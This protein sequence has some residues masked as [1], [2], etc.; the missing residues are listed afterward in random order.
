MRV[1]RGK[2]MIIDYLVGELT[3]IFG[4]LDPDAPSSGIW[5]VGKATF[6]QEIPTMTE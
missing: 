2:T 3:R 1:Q 5:E 6:K 4:L